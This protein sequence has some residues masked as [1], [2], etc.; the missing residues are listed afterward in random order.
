MLLLLCLSN[1]LRPQD[2]V[3][4]HGALATLLTISARI[5][6]CPRH[7]HDLLIA[8][9]PR[10][11]QYRLF[12]IREEGEA[13]PSENCQFWLLLYSCLR[14]QPLTIYL[15]EM[16]MQCVP[17]EIALHNGNIHRG[18][19]VACQLRHG[20]ILAADWRRFHGSAEVSRIGNHRWDSQRNIRKLLCDVVM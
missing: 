14:E 20:A 13:Q 17:Q 5:P 12:R 3:L 1:R 7:V 10:F 15:L 11:L 18:G 16:F 8:S 9:L 2:P 4:T 6:A 19:D